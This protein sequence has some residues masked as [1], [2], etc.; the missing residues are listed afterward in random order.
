M[1]WNKLALTLTTSLLSGLFSMSSAQVKITDGA[2]LT[3][4]VNSILELESSN[5]G[6]LV[7]RMAVNNLDQP[8]PL[9]SPVPAGMLVYSTGGMVADGYYFWNGSKWISFHVAETLFS[10]SGSAVLLKSETFVLATGDITLTLPAVTG[11]DNG[12]AITVKNT[13][14]HLDLITVEGNSGALIDGSAQFIA[15]KVAFT[16][17]CCLGR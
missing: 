9:T 13:G 11:A 2:D 12:L 17:V 5:K 16:N 7:P 10:K 8:D 15:D 3:P 6:L 4:N 1:N 14:T